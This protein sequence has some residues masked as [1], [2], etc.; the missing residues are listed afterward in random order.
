M[1]LGVKRALKQDQ[2]DNQDGMD[3]AFVMIDEA[4]KC[5]YFAGANNPLVYVQDGVLNLIKGDKQ[6]IG[7][8][9]H[10]P[11]NKF[12]QHAVSFKDTASTF[13]I[14]SD[15]YQDQFGGEQNKK[16]MKPRFRQLLFDIH[17]LPM[18]K[19]HE[20]LANTLDNWKGEEPQVDDI[21]V[22]GLKLGH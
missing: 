20:A 10:R 11:N 1:H 18:T 6:G 17:H 22:M 7:G 15:G 16:F 14:F 13:Y 19:Q 3:M 12:T 8:G 9:K 21:L 2:T 4:E 5:L